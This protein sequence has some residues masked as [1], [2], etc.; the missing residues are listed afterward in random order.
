MQR[1]GAIPIKSFSH[2]LEAESDFS[3]PTS[4]CDFMSP[5]RSSGR[6]NQLYLFI[7]ILYNIRFPYV[8]GSTRTYR[9]K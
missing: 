3:Y 2:Y 1:Y 7:A 4:I 5:E 9:R 8:T 6:L